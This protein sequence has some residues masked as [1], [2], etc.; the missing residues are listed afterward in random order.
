[1]T[2]KIIMMIKIIV[3]IIIKLI[4][5]IKVK[6]VYLNKQYKFA[7]FDRNFTQKS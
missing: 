3:I 1:M 7:S 4:I 5:H 6:Y 2:M